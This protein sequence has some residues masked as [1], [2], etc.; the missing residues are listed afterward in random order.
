MIRTFLRAQSKFEASCYGAGHA[1]DL[2]LSSI[3]ILPRMGKRWK[4]T[5]HQT[6]SATFGAMP[7]VFLTALFTGMILGLQAGLTLREFGQESAIGFLVSASMCREMGPIFT[8]L[9][10]AGLIGSTYA[11]ELGTMKIS[12]E[13]DALEVMSIDPIRFLVLPRIIA[14]AFTCAVLTIFADIIGILGGGLVGQAILNVDFNLYMKNAREA[15]QL[16][17]VYG[18]IFKSFIFGLSIASISCSQGLRAEHGAQGVG[19]ATM[20]AVVISFILVLMF[21]YFLSW[22]IY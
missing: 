15:L 9:P 12:E 1:V 2:L 6:A 14:L 16:K 4:E 7:V 11:A 20:K 3:L 19:K 5:L 18:G 17:D 22:M 8:A 21:D 10:I 13:I